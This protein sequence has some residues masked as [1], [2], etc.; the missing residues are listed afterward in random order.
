MKC[1]FQV[2][3][4]NIAQVAVA[5]PDRLVFYPRWKWAFKTFKRIGEGTLINRPTFSESRCYSWSQKP[6]DNFWYPI[7]L[8]IVQLPFSWNWP[9][10]YKALR[11]LLYIFAVKIRAY[12]GAL[13]IRHVRGEKF[14][15]LRLR[16]FLPFSGFL[17]LFFSSR[18]SRDWTIRKFSASLWRVNHC[19]VH[20][21]LDFYSVSVSR[22]VV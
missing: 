1:P 12:A 13:C 11:F 21:N 4:I 5:H 2:S 9:C 3:Q 6:C 22:G 14:A 20:V 17:V 8:Y 15:S 19:I 10:A 16:K 7:L 18:L